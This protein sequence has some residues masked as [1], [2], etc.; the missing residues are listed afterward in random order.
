MFLFTALSGLSQNNKNGVKKSQTHL[1]LELS[2]HI[3]D[4]ML[5]LAFDAF[6]D[7]RHFSKGEVR[8]APLHSAS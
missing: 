7:V 6:E 2:A 5:Q 4:E 1:R 8:Q 3:Q